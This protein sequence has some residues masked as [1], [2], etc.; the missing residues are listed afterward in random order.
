MTVLL[1]DLEIASRS[2]ARHGRRNALLGGAIAA[3]TALMVLLGGLTAGVRDGMVQSATTFMSG[4]VNVGGYF[5]IASGTSAPVVSD[6]RKVLVIARAAVPDLELAT[7]RGR[8]FARAVGGSGALDLVLAGIDVQ[9]EGPRF[10]R[11]VQVTQGRLDDLAQPGT[12]LLFEDEAKRLGVRVGDALTLVASTVRGEKNSVDVRVV[13]VARNV[14]LLSSFNAFLP[15]GTLRQLHRLRP[16]AAGV[17]QL[18]IRDPAESLRV[19]A[20]VRAA[21]AA[22]GYRM[23]DPDPRSYW[24]KLASV[25]SQDWVGQRLDVSTWQD[26]LSSLTWILCALQ[27]LGAVLLVALMAIVVVGIVNTLAIAVRERTREIGTLRAIGMQRP[28]VLWLFLLEAALLGAAG[29]L[30][31][32]LVGVGL[33]TA[34]NHARL[35]LPE[36]VRTVILQQHLALA[37]RP[38]SIV[39]SA[40][41]IAGSTTVAALFPAWRAA[42]LPPVTAMHHIG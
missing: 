21:L 3:V 7:V 39:T 11:V 4:H 38:A 13:A 5:K 42:R 15:S 27:G 37:L 32:S 9:S 29:A 1:T 26:E 35:A 25:T 17:I 19:A 20:K 41:V 40:C 18:Y 36:A 28:K 8:G 33:A 34:L 2:L 22:A 24:E 31:G 16:D 23:L 10:H 14:G 12:I 30:A 6:Y